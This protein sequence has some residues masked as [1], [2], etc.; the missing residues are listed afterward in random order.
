MTG[1]TEWRVYA[2]QA[3]IADKPDELATAH[4]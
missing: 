4:E 3:H 1:E 2:V